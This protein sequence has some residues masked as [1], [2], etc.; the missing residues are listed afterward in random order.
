MPVHPLSDLSVAEMK[1]AAALVR[2]LHRGQELA[3]KAITLEEPPKDLVIKYLRAQEHGTS[4]PSIPRVA[5]AAYYFKG[6]VRLPEDYGETSFTFWAD[7]FRRTASSQLMLISPTTS[8]T[9]RRE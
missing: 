7:Q 6:T 8:L 4:L 5:F 9:V 1:H 2:Q 3:F